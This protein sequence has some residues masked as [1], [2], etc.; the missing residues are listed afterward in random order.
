[1]TEARDTTTAQKMMKEVL[2]NRPE[3]E[4]K[5]PAFINKSAHSNIL[6]SF[7]ATPRFYLP[8]VE[9]T[10]VALGVWEL[11]LGMRLPRIWE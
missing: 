3:G 8:T 4:R 11:G 9:K 10:H 5:K 2:A 6:A 1:M 7:Q